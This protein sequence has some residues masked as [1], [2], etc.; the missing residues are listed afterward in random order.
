[1]YVETCHE[2][3][4]FFF[5]TK[6]ILHC[7]IDSKMIEKISMIIQIWYYFWNC[8]LHF[9]AQSWVCNWYLYIN[10]S[11]VIHERPK[12]L[13]NIVEE[14]VGKRGTERKARERERERERAQSLERNLRSRNFLWPPDTVCFAE[15][16][17]GTRSPSSLP[18]FHFPGS[19][20][21]AARLKT[22]SS[23]GALVRQIIERVF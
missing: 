23:L 12:L 6:T 8:N 10:T 22:K 16:R 20:V 2:I 3:K 13:L 18:L 19:H 5:E 9:T 21:V 4:T 14:K 15:A 1:L 7:T 17:A 11:C